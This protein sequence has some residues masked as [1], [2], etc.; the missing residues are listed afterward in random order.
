MTFKQLSVG[1]TFDF[2]SDTSYDSFY[3][4]CKKTSARGYVAINSDGST[5]K[6]YGKMRVGSLSAKVYHV[7]KSNPTRIPVG[8]FIKVEKIR[9]HPGGKKVDIVFRSRKRK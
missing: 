5:N 4:R 8:K 9:V 6:R 2:V 7:S 3:E 1:D